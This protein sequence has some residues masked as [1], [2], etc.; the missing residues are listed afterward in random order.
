MLIHIPRYCTSLL[1]IYL[2][3]VIIRN[4]TIQHAYNRQKKGK[5]KVSTQGDYL[6]SMVARLW[7]VKE[8]KFTSMGGGA[9]GARAL[10]PRKQYL[11]FPII[12]ILYYLGIFYLLLSARFPF[13]FPFSSSTAVR[14]A[15]LHLRL[16]GESFNYNFNN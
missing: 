13:H 2:P 11:F 10:V 12:L 14:S 3:K 1:A 6:W 15:K 9:R 8:S 5:G 7:G 4:S 16:T